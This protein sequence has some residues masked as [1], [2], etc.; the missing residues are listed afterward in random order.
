MRTVDLAFDNYSIP[1]LPG[2]FIFMT[3]DIKKKLVG[4]AGLTMEDCVTDIVRRHC[5]SL[6]RRPSQ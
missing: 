2:T 3:P 1:K 6:M 4:R 5:V